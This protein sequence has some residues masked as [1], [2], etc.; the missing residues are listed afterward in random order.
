VI[1]E[2]IIHGVEEL[3]EHAL[4]VDEPFGLLLDAILH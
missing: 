4:S 3:D 2:F 1:V